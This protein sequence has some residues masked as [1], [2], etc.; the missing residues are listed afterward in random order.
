MRLQRIAVIGGYQHRRRG[1]VGRGNIAA[2]A[3]HRAIARAIGIARIQHLHHR[4]VHA[5][6][7]GM[8]DAQPRRVAHIEPREE[9]ALLQHPV[10]QPGQVLAI[11]GG[12]PFGQV[13]LPEQR[14]LLRRPDRIAAHREAAEQVGM[15]LERSDKDDA[16]RMEAVGRAPL[17]PQRRHEL[18]QRI[19][20]IVDLGGVIAQRVALAET[21][22]IGRDAGKVRAPRFHQRGIFGAAARALVHHQQHRPA[23]A[24][25]VMNAAAIRDGQHVPCNHRCFPLAAK[26]SG[27]IYARHSP[28][29][30]YCRVS[31][32]DWK[33]GKWRK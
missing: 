4:S 10:P 9:P 31:K 15:P 24:A 8:G 3:Q 11:I 30:L 20:E 14:H 17:H 23:A 18:R 27:Q 12:M 26:L 13:R 1:R 25:A 6:Q 5:R 2:G 21:G 33:G 29:P 22:R 19:G 7:V 28:R 32:L 16:A